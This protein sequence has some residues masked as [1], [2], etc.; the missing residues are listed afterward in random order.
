VTDTT[1]TIVQPAPVQ[2]KGMSLGARAFGVLLAPYAT[3]ADVAARPRVLGALILVVLISAG[4]VSAFLSTETGQ[5]ATLDQQ[6]AVMESMGFQLTDEQ[7]A[8]LEQT[9]DRAAYFAAAGQVVVLPLLAATVSGVLLAIFNVLLGGDAGFKQVLAIVV[10]S[11]FVMALQT[12]FTLPLNY[13]VTGTLDSPTTL[14]VFF[15]MFDASSFPARALGGIDLFRAWWIISLS[16]GLAVLYKRKAG[17]IAGSFLTA[18]VVLALVIAV[19]TTAF[20]GA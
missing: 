1:T 13:Y 10:H 3:Y 17:S 6:A 7:Y 11:G 5:I 9:A 15:P 12:V 20:S 8:R 2:A 14:S 19:V 18:Y 16:I 4:A